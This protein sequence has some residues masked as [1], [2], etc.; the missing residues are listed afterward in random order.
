MCKLYF[1]RCVAHDHFLDCRRCHFGYSHFAFCYL[2]ALV[3]DFLKRLTICGKA[4]RI[5]LKCDWC[6]LLIVCGKRCQVSCL[7][8]N[9]RILIMCDIHITVFVKSVVNLNHVTEL[10]LCNLDIQLLCLADCHLCL[11]AVKCKR[12]RC[13]C[14][15]EV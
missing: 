14:L 10:Y 3:C 4:Y 12:L 15:P 9:A 11:N 2:H 6:R 7:R 8:V 5:C 13:H 1:C